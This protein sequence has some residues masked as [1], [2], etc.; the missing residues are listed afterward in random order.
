MNID[1]EIL[2]FDNAEELAGAAA[3]RFLN[4]AKRTIGNQ[5]RFT[6]A[7]SGGN[8]PR[9]VYEL[10]ASDEFKTKLRGKTFTSS[11]AMSGRSLKIILPATTAW[12]SPRCFPKFRFLDQTYMR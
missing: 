4:Q 2:I 12:L 8:T 6:V 10:L 5:G 9:R 11:S 7:L 3:I 1:P